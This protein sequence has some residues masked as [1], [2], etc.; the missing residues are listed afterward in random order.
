LGNIS[1]SIFG[2]PKMDCPSEENL[3]RLKLAELA[4]LRLEFDLDKRELVVFHSETLPSL[5]FALSSL[6][7]GAK[8]L[9]SE[10]VEADSPSLDL[11][12][13]EASQKKLLIIVLIINFAFFFIELISGLFS[14]SLGLIADSLDMLADAM[15]Y[16]ISLAAIGA[17]ISRKKS[18][19]KIAGILQIT[20]AIMGFSEVLR[21]FFGTEYLPEFRTMI[22]VSL[23]ALA[24]NTASLLLLSR[25]K[26]KN[27][28]H[29]RASMIF[30]SNDIIINIG[31]IFA[32]ILVQFCQSPLPDLFIGLLVFIIVLRGAKSI[33]S[34][35]K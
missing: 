13:S 1:R 4:I 27:E 9:T 30:T 23:F 20:L 21:R 26:G 5:E 22:I 35:S 25:S 8:L 24:A 28:I 31:V 15:V 10:G 33:L 17:T 34:L 2:I 7:F 11:S 14:A 6:G 19:A 3:I 18:V 12:K 32:A 29:M 16:G